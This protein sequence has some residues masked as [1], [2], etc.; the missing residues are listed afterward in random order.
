MSTDER[1]NS[2]PKVVLVTGASRYLGGYL[3]TRLARNEAIDRVIAVDVESPSKDMLRRMGRAEFVRADIRNPLIG[4]VVNGNDVDTVVHA[5]TVQRPPKGGSRA[6][7]KDM[8]VLGAM[9]L[10]AVCN[11]A[12]SV[13]SVILRSSSAVYGCS[14]KDPAM[15][16][17]EMSAQRRP[18]GGF[19]HDMIEIEGFLR[20]LARRRPDIAISILRTAPL[21]GPRHNGSVSRYFTSPVVPTIIGRDARLQLLHEEDALA[22]MERA[23][24]VGRAGTFN[25]AADGTM[26]MSQAI[27]RAGAIEVPMP[28]RLF[29]SVGRVLMGPMMR[30][31]TKEQLEYFNFGC[32]LDTRRMRTDLGFEPRWTTIQAFDDFVQGNSIKPVVDPAWVDRGESA[33]RG[34]VAAGAGALR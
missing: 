1:G 4:K 21:I 33:L 11:N 22:A 15:F 10:F 25:V 9:Q 19:A 7:M 34:L 30:D 28:M 24:T 6:A 3:V 20:G 26:M 16:T 2:T 12:P 32:G 17:E 8:N 31:F 5:S 23:A 27:R 13:R 29:R 18:S 14:P